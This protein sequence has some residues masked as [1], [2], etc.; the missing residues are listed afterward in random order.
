MLF[1]SSQGSQTDTATGNRRIWLTAVV[2]IALLISLWFLPIKTYLSNALSVV[3]DLGPAG[4]AALA[5]FYIGAA[6]FM[7]PGSILTLG[8]GFLFGI[9]IGILTVWVGATLGACAAF[10]VGRTVARAWVKARIGAHPRFAAVDE[11]VAREGLKI[12][13]LLRLSPLFPYNLL[14]YALG[15]T[16]ISF[17]DYAVATALGMIPVMLMYVYLGAAARSLT[18][19]ASGTAAAGGPGRVLF[20]V[21]LITTVVATTLVTGIARRALHS[22]A[23]PIE[24]SAKASVLTM[25]HQVIISPLD[26]AN[27]RLLANVRP[28]GWSNPKAGGTYNLVVIGAGSGGLVTAAGAAGLGA[29]VALIERDLLG[30]D[31]LNVGCVPS[32]SLLAASRVVAAT[33]KAADFGIDASLQGIRFSDVM[34]RMRRVRADLSRNDSARRFRDLG[35]D[36]FLGN[37]SFADSKSIRVGEDILTFEKAV[38]ATGARAAQPDYPGLAEVG[39]LTNESVFNLTSA[40]KRLAVI[41]AGPIGC[42]LAQA[43]QRLGMQV[44]LIHKHTRILEREDP[45]AAAIV[46]GRFEREGVQ[47]LLGASIREFSRAEDGKSIALNVGGKDFTLTVDEILVGVGRRP[48]I[49]SLNL[50]EAG[51]STTR[52]GVMVD[53]FLRTT[54]PDVYAVGDV[55]MNLK[56]TH[57]AD[58]T[59][60]LV[61][62]NALFYGRGRVSALQIPWCT[63]TDP[64]IAHI[65]LYE[66]DAEERNIPLETFKRD[67]KDVDRAVTDG[68]EDGFVK[69]H[70]KRGSDQIIGATI[71]GAHAGDLISQVSLAMSAGVGL[72]KIANAIYPYPTRSDAIRLAANAYNASRLSPRM[73]RLL[74]WWFA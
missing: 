14:N 60:R 5:I 31:C 44:V 24:S 17:R 27:Q 26:E 58:A 42:E 39:Y 54:N 6:V 45:E 70:V 36:V 64:E 50:A 22:A 71:V 52:G 7:V 18:D 10:L 28:A 8:A 16:R 20:W 19:I 67:F 74:S 56:F 38:I 25:P 47:L 43:F 9:P 4:P 29:R 3:A 34:E 1:S 63:Y 35:V 21:G 68:E 62:R 32:K 55:C 65:G 69:I 72:K 37:G 57:A 30:G 15:L 40:P 73:K 49:E 12:V 13:L 11:A 53:D 59:A 46:Q 66:E 2:V 23:H 51:V 41:G 61:L 48:N 33:R